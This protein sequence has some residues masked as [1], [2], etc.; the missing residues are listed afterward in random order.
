MLTCP[1]LTLREAF[2]SCL[3]NLVSYY[4]EFGCSQ[5]AYKYGFGSSHRFG[6]LDTEGR[7]E[8]PLVVGKDGKLYR[9]PFN[10]QL[11]KGR[12]RLSRRKVKAPEGMKPMRLVIEGAEEMIEEINVKGTH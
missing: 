4:S 9:A 3:D 6:W 12:S 2:Q 1:Q 11:A 5:T 7:T 10:I 8:L